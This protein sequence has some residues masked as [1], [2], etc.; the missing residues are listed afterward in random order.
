VTAELVD[1]PL[2]LVTVMF[3]GLSVEL[4]VKVPL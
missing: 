4:T 2:L 3:L 1:A